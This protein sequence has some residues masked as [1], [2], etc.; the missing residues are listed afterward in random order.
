[1]RVTKC[2]LLVENPSISV[3]CL[4][5][6]IAVTNRRQ[7][8]MHTNEHRFLLCAQTGKLSQPTLQ[9][10]PSTGERRQ[11]IKQRCRFK[12]PKRR[13]HKFRMVEAL[14]FFYR[15][16]SMT[17]NIVLCYPVETRHLKLFAERFPDARTIDAGQ[18][19]TGEAIFQADIFVGHAKVPAD[20]QGVVQQRRLQ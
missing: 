12:R 4:R 11:C 15:D 20:W 5:A 10:R 16:I 13:T 7:P 17:T 14:D 3:Y 19:R 9:L 18:E 1:M 2:L 6:S 8:Q